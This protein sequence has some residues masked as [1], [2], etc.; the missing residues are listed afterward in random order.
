LCS[1]NK[2][3]EHGSNRNLDKSKEHAGSGLAW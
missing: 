2:V 3:E 1:K